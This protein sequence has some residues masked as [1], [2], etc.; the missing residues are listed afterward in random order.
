MPEV[1]PSHAAP[2]AAADSAGRRRDP[3]ALG[4]CGADLR[5]SGAHFAHGLALDNADFFAA[6]AIKAGALQAYA[7]TGAPAAASRRIPLQS[8]VGLSDSLLSFAQAD[9]TR[10]VNAGW[11]AEH[12]LQYREVSGGH[13]VDASDADAAAAWLCSWA[14]TP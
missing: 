8:R 14:V 11:I 6:Y 12:D 4:T 9:A 3:L 10:F 1:L 7:G 13:S 2:I 5:G